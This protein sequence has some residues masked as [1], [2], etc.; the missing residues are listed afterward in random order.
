[1]QSNRWIVCLSCSILVFALRTSSALVLAADAIPAYRFVTVDIPTP[2]G[3]FGF[4]TLADI[5][6]SGEIS[7]GFTDTNLGAF[8]FVL[9]EKM[10]EILCGVPVDVIAALPEAINKH[11]E[12][13][14]SATVV[15]ERIP[16][17]IPP[18]EI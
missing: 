6:E 14:G 3:Q 13:A 2:K 12:I 9:E 8:G 18:F 15:I 5:N 7:G 11:G 4:T 16:S 10:G 1:M 17:M